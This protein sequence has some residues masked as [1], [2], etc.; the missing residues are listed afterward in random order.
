ML[1]AIREIAAGH[2]LSEFAR[3][4]AK[5]ESVLIVSETY[6]PS[7]RLRSP[8]ELDCLLDELCFI[9]RMPRFP[10]RADAREESRLGLAIRAR[11]MN[12]SGTRVS[13]F[14]A[15]QMSLE[16]DSPAIYLVADF[17]FGS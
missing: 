2:G 1:A 11:R 16:P 6:T 3:V 12:G 5:L 13:N 9:S 4:A 8:R 7:G 15:V 10:A 17:I 14:L